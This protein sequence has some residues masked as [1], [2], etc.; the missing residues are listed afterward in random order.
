M[1]RKLLTLENINPL[2][3]DIQSEESEPTVKRAAEIERELRKGV[4][5][6]FTEVIR[7][8]INDIQAMGQ[9]P[10]TFIRQVLTMCAYPLLL[11]DPFIPSDVKRRANNILDEC[12]GRSAGAYT[13]S[14]GIDLIREHVAQY[15]ERRDG[16]PAY[17]KNVILTSGSNEALRS[18]LNVLNTPTNGNKIGVLVP[19]PRDPSFTTLLKEFGMIQ[20]D[21]YLEEEQDWSINSKELISALERASRYC[22]PKAILVINPGNP[23]GSLLTPRNMEEI[24]W[25]AFSQKLVLLADEV[26]TKYAYQFNAL[27]QCCQFQS[28]KKTIMQMGHPFDKLELISMMSGSTGILGESGLRSGCCELINI[29]DEVLNVYKKSIC[30]K[31]CPG[32]LGQIAFDCMICPPEVKEPSYQRFMQEWRDIMQSLTEKA[33]FLTSS[34]NLIDGIEC[35]QHT[36]ATFVFLKLKIPSKAVAAAKGKGQTPDTFYAMQLLEEAGICSLPG[37]LYG[38]LPGTHHLRL[39]ILPDKKTIQDMVEKIRSFH[40]N[41]IQMYS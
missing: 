12:G 28:F 39:T 24:V 3:R 14:E 31:M 4:L 16:F 13:Y 20:I 25:F 21:Y 11:S 41:F 5:K 22:I 40:S 32:V 1:A 23:T 30:V 36:A 7:A 8:D 38:Q 17:A 6:P 18:I 37:S 10:I 2:L 33:I 34:L 19:I 35:K 9:K 27:G 15:M 29:T 26:S